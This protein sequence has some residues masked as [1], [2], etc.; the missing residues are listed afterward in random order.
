MRTLND[1]FS[2]GHAMSAV[3][4]ATN[5]TTPQFV[6]ADAGALYS[7]V[8]HVHVVGDAATVFTFTKN[9]ATMTG[10]TFTTQAAQTDES[11]VEYVLSGTET[12]R[13]VE[14]GDSIIALSGGQQVAA[15]TA[16]VTFVIRR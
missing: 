3:Q 5:P 14:I 7:M 15:Q 1:Y 16:D 10:V 4:T 8:L 9:G 11:G 13:R 6:C 12:N 2:A